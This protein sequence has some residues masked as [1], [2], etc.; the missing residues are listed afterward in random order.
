M[1]RA[2]LALLLLAN[3]LYFAWAQGWL[4][5]PPRHAEREPARLAAQQGLDAVRLLPPAR[6]DDAVAAAREAALVCVEIGPLAEPALSEAEYR[7]AAALVAPGAVAREEVGGPNQWWVHGGRYPEAG[8]RNA[9][10]EELRRL[11]LRFERVTR[12]PELAPGFVLS[13]HDSRE[14]AEAWLRQAP[15]ALR[16]ARVV[17]APGSGNS[18]GW[19]LRVAQAS[20]EQAEKLKTDEAGFRD[21]AAR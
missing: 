15:R 17:A 14:A 13:R 19:R 5:A 1:L 9:R 18:A 16:G 10:E 20:P 6:A 8:P 12:P 3:G 2:L 4:G 11:G 7:L 21:C